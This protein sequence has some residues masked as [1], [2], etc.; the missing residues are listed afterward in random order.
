MVMAINIEKILTISARDW[1][2]INGVRLRDYEAQGVH[3]NSFIIDI[4][5]KFS[6]KVPAEA[7]VVIDY[8][9]SSAGDSTYTRAYACGTALIPKLF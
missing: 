8:R 7:E 2:E 9:V 6:E 5:K 1:A 4:L 3:E